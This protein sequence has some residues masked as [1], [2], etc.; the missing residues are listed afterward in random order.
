MIRPMKYRTYGT[1]EF[2]TRSADDV[3]RTLIQPSV[4]GEFHQ[5]DA[6]V[7]MMMFYRHRASPKHRYDMIEV[8]YDEGAPHTAKRSRDKLL[9]LE[10]PPAPVYKG[11]GGRRRP[12]RGGRA[13]EESYFHRE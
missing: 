7:T 11:P 5:H 1:S 4:E 10:V 13:R 6:V 8:G 3:P 12:A 9:C 2:S